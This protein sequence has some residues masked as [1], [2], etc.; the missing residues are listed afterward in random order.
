M[1]RN[2]VIFISS[3]R[4]T[5]VPAINFFSQ[6]Q[7]NM[8]R[9]MLTG[10]RTDQEMVSALTYVLNENIAHIVFIN[11]HQEDP[12]DYI[13]L[14]FDRSGYISSTLNL[15]LEEIP[16]DTI[17]LVSAAPKSDFLD[18]EIVKLERF[19]AFGG[20]VMILY[21]FHTQSLP[22]L[23]AFLAQWGI[24][25]E[26]KLVFDEEFT[27][28]PQLGVIGAHVV[29]GALPSTENAEIITTNS[30]PMGIFLAR[31]M[32]NLWADGSRGG[33]QLHPMISTFSAS[34]YSKDIG[35]GGIQTAERESGDASGPFVLA[36]NARLM[37]RD[38]D[39][40]QTNANLI[41]GNASMF[42]DMFLS[43]Y[44]STFYNP[45]LLADLANDLNPFGEHVFIP[46]RALSD[47]QLLMSIAGTRNVLIFMVIALPLAI[48]AAGVFVWR[49]RR[50]K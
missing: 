2:D 38:S 26:N 49:K 28:I 23:D 47:S 34:S 5:L 35:D 18:E 50:H 46:P 43:M 11:N 17:L 36:Y 25:V 13:N 20:N 6:S 42:D 29:S 21:D 9:S 8:G 4:A 19:L 32:S 1:S 22:R 39:G 14:V 41:V 12:S 45:M 30:I 31:P 48:I 16:D 33:I 44:A 24:V 7:D 10:V 37:A 15:A 3:R 27:F 40:N